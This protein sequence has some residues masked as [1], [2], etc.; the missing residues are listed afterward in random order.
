M[1]SPSGSYQSSSPVDIVRTPV[2]YA[3]PKFHT[4]S[5]P[6]KTLPIPVFQLSPSN[7]PTFSNTVLLLN[8]SNAPKDQSSPKPLPF[9]KHDSSPFVPKKS[10]DSPSSSHSVHLENHY[11]NNVKQKVR[12]RGHKPKPTNSNYN[13]ET[14][15]FNRP[16]SNN[17]LSLT[18]IS[19]NLKQML[20]IVDSPAS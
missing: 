15:P 5:P 17:D 7:S 6:P 1:S 10:H 11:S 9:P 4:T 3:G 13:K 2:K 14:H 12:S 16:K 20:R 18:Q 19:V 8:K